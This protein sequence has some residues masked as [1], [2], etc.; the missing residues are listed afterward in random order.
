MTGGGLKHVVFAAALIGS[1][2]YGCSES[3]ETF[4]SDLNPKYFTCLAYDCHQGTQLRIYPPVSGLHWTNMSDDCESCHYQYYTNPLHQNGYINGYDWLFG[5]NAPGL[6][7]FYKPDSSIKPGPVI[8]NGPI[9]DDATGECGSFEC[10]GSQMDATD[11]W[12]APP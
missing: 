11:Q 5:V 7:V 6:I 12:Y 4:L 1:V 3:P 9:W 2:A 10:H 8:P